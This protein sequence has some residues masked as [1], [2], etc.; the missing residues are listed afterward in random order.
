MLSLDRYEVER[1]LGE[2]GFGSVFAATRL[3]DG[4]RVAIKEIDL[5]EVDNWG[6][7]EGQRVPL[8]VEL[9]FAL[10]HIPVVIPLYEYFRRGD[11]Y[12]LV[13]E[14]VPGA[15]SLFDYVRAHGPLGEDQARHVILK[16]ADVV[17][18]CFRS[19]V[20]HRDIKAENVLLLPGTGQ[21]RLIDFGVSELVV[22]QRGADTG[23]TVKCWPPE[24]FQ[25][26][27]YLHLPATVWSLGTL[28][29]HAVCGK[30]AFT[31]EVEEIVRGSPEFPSHVSLLCQDLVARCF[32]SEPWQRISLESFLVHPW[33]T[34]WTHTPLNQSAT[35]EHLQ[36][37][38]DAIRRLPHR[39]TR[40]NDAVIQ[41]A[42]RQVWKET[43]RPGGET[44]DKAHPR[45]KSASGKAIK[46]KGK[47]QTKPKEKALAR[48]KMAS[49]LQKKR[50]NKK[51]QLANKKRYHDDTPQIKARGDH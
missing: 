9:L 23:G 31:E 35:Y 38:I 37:G 39:R 6:M 42:T 11:K 40:R 27:E 13:I 4:H 49:L 3:E 17:A 45:F 1:K 43:K 8:E 30:S 50:E 32:I 29:Y 36:K 51:Q 28:L 7:H 44:R 33:A 47:L 19:G 5:A 20:S 41:L 22:S 18:Q 21:I 25:R 48:N 12:Y 26:H 15:V 34:G 46:G 2:G 16:V 14:Y 24:Y 10:Q